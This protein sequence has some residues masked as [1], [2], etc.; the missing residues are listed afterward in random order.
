MGRERETDVATGHGMR[1]TIVCF[2]LLLNRERKKAL[3]TSKNPC[4]FFIDTHAPPSQ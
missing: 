1:R 4:D 2:N 3:F